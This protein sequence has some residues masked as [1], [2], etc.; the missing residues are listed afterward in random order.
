MKKVLKNQLGITLIALVVTIVVLLILAAVSIQMLGGENGIITQATKAKDVTRIQGIKESVQIWE[1][2]QEMNELTGGN[3]TTDLIEELYEKGLITA[4]EKTKLEN[5]ESII[6]GKGKEWEEEISLKATLVDMYELALAEGCT[7][8]STCTN[9]TAHLHIGDYVNYKNPSTGSY[10]VETGTLGIEGEQT[11][12]VSKNQ[13]NWRVLG[14]DKTT[15]GIKLIAG[16]PMKSNREETDGDPYLYMKGAKSYLNA[17]DELNEI[18]ALYKNEFATR[19]RSVNMDDIDE[20]TG[21][22]TEEKIKEVNLDYYSGNKQYGDSYS[23]SNHYTPQ[24]WINGETTTVS[25]TVDGYLYSINS[26]ISSDM[27]SVTVANTRAY[28]MLFNNVEYPTGK[29]YWLASRGVYAGSSYAGFGPGDVYSVDGVPIAFS[30]GSMFG[31]VGG[32]A[33]SFGA[34][35]PV[36]ILKSEV[37]EDKVPKIDDKTETTWNYTHNLN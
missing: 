3:A 30:G 16:S 32:E 8:G 23:F 34:V 20:I 22:T 5:G 4:E 37:T 15:G 33:E 35:R 9:P 36:V 13:L 6:I 1:A 18:G 24:S 10:T 25:G 27:P 29:C 14:K 7:G 17:I 21:V 12:D 26:K 19:A 2:N 28:E 11:F 31:S